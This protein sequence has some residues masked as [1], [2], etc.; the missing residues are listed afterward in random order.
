MTNLA[1]FGTA[2]AAYVEYRKTQRDIDFAAWCDKEIETQVPAHPSWIYKGAKLWYVAKEDGHTEALEVAD[3]QYP[4]NKNECQVWFTDGLYLALPEVLAECIPLPVIEEEPK[5]PAWVKPGARLVR[6]KNA[7]V[8]NAGSLN[9]VF[10]VSFIF[11]NTIT[12]QEDDS[13]F[14]PADIIAGDVIEVKLPEWVK[15]G[16]KYRWLKYP[17]SDLYTIKRLDYNEQK[18]FSGDH[19]FA[20]FEHFNNGDIVEIV[21][22]PKFPA[23]VK[24]GQWIKWKDVRYP[25]VSKIAAVY[26]THEKAVLADSTHKEPHVTYTDGGWDRISS[27]LENYKPVTIKPWTIDEACTFRRTKEHVSYSGG[28]QGTIETITSYVDGYWFAK[29]SSGNE[30]NAASLATYGETASHK[31]CGTF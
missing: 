13:W 26:D 6:I 21:E 2:C 27:V 15:V 24:V 4:D 28:D 10:T 9:K 31:P 19:S 11:T 5:L 29:T 12:V 7:G 14:A 8:G 16:A 17:D 18:S 30:F 22:E 3:I 1:K 25:A 20:R 23:W